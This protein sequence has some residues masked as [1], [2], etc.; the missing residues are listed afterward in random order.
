MTAQQAAI[1][2]AIYACVTFDRERHSR[3][4]PRTPLP[5]CSRPAF[6]PW[7]A[8]TLPPA[9]KLGLPQID[10]PWRFFRARKIRIV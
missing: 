6:E 7:T 8:M 3:I 1:R 2:I 9:S 4:K 5:V 10:S